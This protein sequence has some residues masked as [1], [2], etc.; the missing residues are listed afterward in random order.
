MLPQIRKGIVCH[1]MHCDCCLFCV[2]F[3]F[4]R[5]LF[6]WSVRVCVCSSSRLYVS[7]CECACLAVCLSVWL[8]MCLSMHMSVCLLVF[9]SARLSLSLR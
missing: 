6:C 4:V 1:P 3:L 2:V 5:S 7:V 8:L 9:L